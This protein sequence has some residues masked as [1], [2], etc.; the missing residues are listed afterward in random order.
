MNTPSGRLLANAQLVLFPGAA[1][2]RS[3]GWM[4]KPAAPLLT[5]KFRTEISRTDLADNEE[6]HA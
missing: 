5:S 2:S 4:I 1:R 6:S 3:M